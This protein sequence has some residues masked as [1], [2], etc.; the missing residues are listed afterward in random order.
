M[1]QPHP[2]ATPHGL[3]GAL[4]GAREI[5]GSRIRSH[6]EIGRSR[7]R[8]RVGK[9][10]KVPEEQGAA[11]AHP[12]QAA[13]KRDRIWYEPLASQHAYTCEEGIAPPTK[14]QTE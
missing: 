12:V 11:A 2:S 3:P 13:S 14:E 6:T 7:R 1:E 8:R 4:H 5:G 9:E 10:L